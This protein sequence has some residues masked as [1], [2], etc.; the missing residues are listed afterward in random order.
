MAVAACG[1]TEH[2]GRPLTNRRFI[3]F[4][5]AALC[6]F[7]GVAGA[8]P[9]P[10]WTLY[11]GFASTQTNLVDMDGNLVKSWPSQFT[12][13]ASVYLLDDGAILRPATD[14]TLPGPNGG[15][16]GGRIQIIGW[17]GSLVWDYVLASATI[18]QHHDALMMPNGNVLA[19]AWEAH[20]AADAI[21]MGRNPA[22]VNFEL[23]S[24]TIYEIRPTGPTSGE[25][26]W[27]WRV[28]DH[29]IQNRD[30]KRPNFGQPSEHPERIDINFSP[31]GSSSD[32]L[33]FNGFDYNQ[34]LDQIILSCHAFSEIWIVSHDSD[35]AGGLMY[36]WGNPRAYGLGSDLD[37]Q[38]F[39][40]HNAQ[41]I[42]DGNPGAGNILVYNNGVGRPGGNRSSVDELAPPLNPDGT[43]ASAPGQPYLPFSPAWTCDH[44]D[45]SPFYSSFISGAQRL[46]NGNTL[47]C[48]GASG[49]FFEV[50]ESCS[51]Q[52]SFAPGGSQ[53]RATRIPIRDVRLRGLLWC[54]PDLAL[55]YGTLDFF[56]VQSF[57]QLF[58]AAD[59]LADM[60]SDGSHDFFDV[61]EFLGGFSD[62][63]P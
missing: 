57:L 48:V 51:T 16:G 7:A 12:P 24:E 26:V 34:T 23:Y 6:L 56:D 47:V 41:W 59:L 38:L 1:H 5:F 20:S 17:D 14:M 45:G 46:A 55:P 15:G 53:F 40:Q 49:E 4:A 50:N 33:H 63:C 61:L 27:T 31:N 58:A 18:R 2:L 43:Y 36:R 19:I 37:R 42:D 11:A 9:E 29:L 28:W 62:G 54:A 30:P 10:G 60:N 32:W 52:W 44:I 25:V 39:K 13:A 35:S 3:C 8:E 21:A 22:T